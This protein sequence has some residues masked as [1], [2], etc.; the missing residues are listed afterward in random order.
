MD[1][2]DEFD[3]MRRWYRKGFLIIEIVGI[4]YCIL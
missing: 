1:G 2:V 4:V 3:I